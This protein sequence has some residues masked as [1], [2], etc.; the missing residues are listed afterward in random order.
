MRAFEMEPDSYMTQYFLADL[1]DWSG[2]F[3]EAINMFNRALVNSN[4]HSWALASFVATCAQRSRKKEAE[5]FFEEL[6]EKS[7]L[8]YIQPATLALA[9][10]AVGENDDALN[11][12]H[13]ACDEHD[14]FLIFICRVHPYSRELRSIKGYE[15]I[16]K[17]MGLL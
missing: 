13:K 16:L 4:R 5:E 11:Y 10:A 15:E 9:A 2:Q 14:P 17:R 6:I 8:E 7:K 1:Y 12:A 3:E